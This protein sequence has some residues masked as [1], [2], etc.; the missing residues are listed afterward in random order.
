MKNSKLIVNFLLTAFL[1]LSPSAWTDDN[2][3][4]YGHKI[5]KKVVVQKYPFQPMVERKVK[6]TELNCLAKAIYYEAGTQS[7]KGKEAVALV[8]LNRTKEKSNFFPSSI[9]HVISQ[10]INRVCQFSYY[11]MKLPKPIGKNWK[12]SKEIAFRI[13]NN[14]VNPQTKKIISNAVYF[15]SVKVSP[16][17][18][19]DRDV[20]FVAKIGDHLFYS[21]RTV[22]F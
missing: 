19:Y 8:I 1:L 15:H 17:W 18:K 7:I 2:N 13:L 16:P 11:C 4:I 21:D 10:K 20:R 6:E 12:E 22:V 5:E 14:V 9:C 3:K